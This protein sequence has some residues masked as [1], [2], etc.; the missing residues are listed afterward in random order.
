M[1]KGQLIEDL[2]NMIEADT[3]HLAKAVAK[4]DRTEAHA[5]VDAIIDSQRK[6][7]DLTR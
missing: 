7:E 5:S 4:G 3:E 2:K 1:N 6:L